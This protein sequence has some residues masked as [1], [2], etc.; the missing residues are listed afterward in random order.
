MTNEMKK[1]FMNNLVNEFKAFVLETIDEGMAEEMDHL[2]LL[3]AC[4][5]TFIEMKSEEF[6]GE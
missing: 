3:E 1:L 6:K 5:M 2:E 4:M